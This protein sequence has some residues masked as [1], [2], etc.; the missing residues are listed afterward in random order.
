MSEIKRY[1]DTGEFYP[2]VSLDDGLRAVEMGI[3]ATAKLEE[4]LYE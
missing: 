2:H 3:E 4:D 1:E